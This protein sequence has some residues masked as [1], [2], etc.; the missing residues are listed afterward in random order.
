MIT[1]KVWKF[2][3]DINTDIIF[4]GRYTYELMSDAMMGKYALEDADSDF[5]AAAQAGDIILAGKNWG[6]GSSREQAAKC[7]KARGIAAV[8]AKGFARIF[9]RN[10]LNEGLLILICPEADLIAQEGEEIT[11]DM[12]RC[13]ILSR[14]GEYRFQTNPP[15]VR[16]LVE[17]GGL[18][19]YTK[20][21]LLHS[22]D[23]PDPN[24]DNLQ[25]E[26]R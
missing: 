4:P 15:Y 11:I 26:E 25:R 9:Y 1:G 19:P 16:G 18:I 17:A 22:L 7:L 10:A 21:R 23:C 6:C 20:K 5:N 8:I 12:D 24:E 14:S 3:D 2:G 13:C